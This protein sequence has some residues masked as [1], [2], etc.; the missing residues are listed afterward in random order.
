MGLKMSHTHKKIRCRQENYA[1]CCFAS[2]RE[3]DRGENDRANNFGHN[4][5]HHSHYNN[6][7]NQASIRHDFFFYYRAIF[8]TRSM[9]VARQI[10][11]WVTKMVA[12]W[13]DGIFF[14][15]IIF[16]FLIQM[17]LDK[18]S[19]K[20]DY[21]IKYIAF[22]NH[23]RHDRYGWLGEARTLP[24]MDKKKHGRKCG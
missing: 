3:I 11:C 19:R 1:Q 24:M 18:M 6:N 7:R 21:F 23:E 13:M 14:A 12:W 4:C 20:I 17:K 16:Y 8:T 22:Y 2:D 15:L 5:N 9:C 10:F